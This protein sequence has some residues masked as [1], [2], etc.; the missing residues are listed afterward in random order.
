MIF[1]ITISCFDDDFHLKKYKTLVIPTN[2]VVR[3]TGRRVSLTIR[4]AKPVGK[5]I[6]PTERGAKPVGKMISPTEQGAKPV[7]KM[8][9]PRVP[10]FLKS[11]KNRPKL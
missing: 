1:K 2:L 9:S 3:L 8:I 6:L 7:G 5:M 11:P 10:H 4:G